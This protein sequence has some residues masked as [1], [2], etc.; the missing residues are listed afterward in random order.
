MSERL[1]ILSDFGFLPSVICVLTPDTRH[2]K[3]KKRQVVV[4][5]QHVTRNS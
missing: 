2:L 4:N 1:I 3:P 5:T